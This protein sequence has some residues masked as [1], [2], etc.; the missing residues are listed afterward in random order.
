MALSSSS[1][2]NSLYER[3]IRKKK[4]LWSRVYIPWKRKIL[5]YYIHRRVS[6]PSAFFTLFFL[7]REWESQI[8]TLLSLLWLYYYSFSIYIYTIVFL[9]SF[10]NGATTKSLKKR[11]KENSAELSRIGRVGTTFMGSLYICRSNLLRLIFYFLLLSFPDDSTDADQVVRV[12]F[13]YSFTPRNRSK[14]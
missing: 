12:I 7:E 13:R 1:L 10:S 3:R 2:W 4:P 9:I 14:K 11:E 6:V 5:L 8:D